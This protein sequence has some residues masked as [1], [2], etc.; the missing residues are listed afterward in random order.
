MGV[1]CFS[2]TVFTDAIVN[3]FTS[4]NWKEIGLTK[5]DELSKIVIYQ[6]IL[7]NI[8]EGSTIYGHFINPE[9]VVMV[10]DE[11]ADFIEELTETLVETLSI[12]DSVTHDMQQIEDES[13]AFEMA[14]GMTSFE[15]I[16]EY[17]KDIVAESWTLLTGGRKYVESNNIVV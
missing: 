5:I 2:P 9:M 8:N 17:L 11:V 3:N 14:T 4:E 16:T 13:E 1:V 10:E 7:E 6:A 12:D 15:A